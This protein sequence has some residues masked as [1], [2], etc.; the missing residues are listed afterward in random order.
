MG[1]LLQVISLGLTITLGIAAF[2]AVARA[3]KLREMQDV[4]DAVN[5]KLSRKR[6]N[7]N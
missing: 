6:S 7:S 4:I 5:R 3:L 2:A 1:F